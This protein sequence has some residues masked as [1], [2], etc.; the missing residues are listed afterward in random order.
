M[1]REVRR[2]PLDFNAPLNGTWVGYENP[3]SRL[4][5]EC[6]HCA[7]TGY[8]PQF[9]ELKEQWYGYDSAFQPQMTGS[10]PFDENHPVV[11]ER[12]RG[13]TSD[14]NLAQRV[15]LAALLNQKW[16]CHLSQDDVDALVAA[17]RLM[18]FTHTWSKEY[19]WT[20]NEQAPHP[21]AEQVNRWALTALGHD[22]INC[23]VVIK[24]RLAKA[25]LP[26]ECAHCQG[27]GSVW[28]SQEARQASEN[29]QREEP[30]VG[31]GW[32]MWQTVSDGPYTPVFKTPEELARYCADNPWG[33]EVASPVSYEQWLSFIKG[34]GLAPSLVVADGQL[35]SGV[36]AS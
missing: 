21:T 8:S 1:G 36:L 2:V 28:P 6:A 29:W 16:S 20:K 22:S 9:N 30:P 3:H 23:H 25:N 26:A 4:A 18:D 5:Q 27:E 12:C 32:Q 24:A 17:N 15:K 34:P 31:E 33:A 11:V 35:V 10:I 13:F 14:S 19:G 7:G